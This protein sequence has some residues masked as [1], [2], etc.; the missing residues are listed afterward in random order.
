MEGQLRMSSDIVH[1][2]LASCDKKIIMNEN[3]GFVLVD[4]RTLYAYKIG[5]IWDLY[6]GFN[7]EQQ[8]SGSSTNFVDSE[9][10]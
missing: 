6:L 3:A 7:V 5:H 8:L 2:S 1:I 9:D 10:V 4:S